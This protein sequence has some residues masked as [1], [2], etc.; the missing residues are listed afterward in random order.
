VKFLYIRFEGRLSIGSGL[1]IALRD[2]RS[3]FRPRGDVGARADPDGRVVT[4]EHGSIPTGRAVE[5][6]TEGD[7]SEGDR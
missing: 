6:E 1:P 7:A 3:L 2:P 5:S 4:S